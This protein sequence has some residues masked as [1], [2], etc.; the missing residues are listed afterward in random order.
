M[1]EIYCSMWSEVLDQAHDRYVWSEKIPNGTVLHVMNCFGHAPEREANDIAQIGIQNGATKV[2]IRCRKW[3]VAGE[4]VSA[5]RDFYIGEYDKIYG[6]FPDAD[7]TD[8]I[9]LHV[10]GVLMTR[11]EFRQ[12]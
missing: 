2:I 12:M 6:Y 4:G 3:N 11:D 1:K 5:F 10:T 8:T 9:E 7:D